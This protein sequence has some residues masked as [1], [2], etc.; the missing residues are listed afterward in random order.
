MDVLTVGEFKAKFS[1]VLE[2]VKKGESVIV[3]YGKSKKKVAVLVPA[4]S[5]KPKKRI[6]GILKGK[7]TVKFSKDFKFKSTEEFLGS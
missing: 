7:A 4:D 5:H 6:L 1:E 3:S 2:K